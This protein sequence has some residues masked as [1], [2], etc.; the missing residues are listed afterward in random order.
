MCFQGCQGFLEIAFDTSKRIPDEPISLALRKSARKRAAY[1]K[2][3]TR[4]KFPARFFFV[5]LS[6]CETSLSSDT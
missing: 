5:M 6:D 3:S 2:I 1:E 4:R